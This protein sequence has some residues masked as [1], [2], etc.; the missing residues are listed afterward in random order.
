MEELKLNANKK[1]KVRKELARME[2]AS[3]RSRR[4]G[5]THKS[6]ES[7]FQI[8]TFSPPLPRRS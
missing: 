8:G 7:R 3:L 4:F 5:L 1:E 6:F 2:T